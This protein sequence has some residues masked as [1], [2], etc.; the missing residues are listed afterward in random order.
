MS[1]GRDQPPPNN[2]EE[3]FRQCFDRLA[4]GSFAPAW[5]CR[6]L[7]NLDAKPTAA[8]IYRALHRALHVNGE[9]GDGEA[10]RRKRASLT[11]AHHLLRKLAWDEA[12]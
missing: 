7:L 3:V 10:G 9:D 8:D 12:K 4:R 2:H 6:E 1:R 5:S 11:A